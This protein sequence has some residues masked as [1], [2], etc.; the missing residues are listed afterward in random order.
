[1]LP[2]RLSPAWSNVTAPWSSAPAGPF[3]G[4]SMPWKTRFKPR[5]WCWSGGPFAVGTRFTRPVAF[6]G[7]D[8]GLVLTARPRYAAVVAK[9]KKL[10]RPRLGLRSRLRRPGSGDPPGACPTAGTVPCG[11]RAVLHRRSD[12]AASGRAAR[13]AAGNAAKPTGERTR[14]IA[15]ANH[16]PGVSPIERAVRRVAVAR[17]GTGRP[18]CC[19]GKLD[20]PYGGPIRRGQSGDCGSRR[21]TGRRAYSRSF[22]D[23]GS[24]KTESRAGV[25]LAAAMTAAGAGVWAQQALRADFE[26]TNRD[27]SATDDRR[28]KP[29]LAGSRSGAVPRRRRRR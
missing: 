15:S 16:A 6:S 11:D 22:E 8:P 10:S 18:S 27:R 3:C 12:A 5:S 28:R 26:T 13:L 23:N 29:T 14:T 20:G 19:S 9:R 24:A 21:A 7:G 4:T 25:I 2:R 1:M 17:A